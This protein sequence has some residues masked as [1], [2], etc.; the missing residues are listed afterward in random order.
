MLVLS[1]LRVYRKDHFDC[2]SLPG[3]PEGPNIETL[4]IGTG[5]L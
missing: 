2:T 5:F 3:D 1:K 4:I